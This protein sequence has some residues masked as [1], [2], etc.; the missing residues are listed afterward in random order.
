MKMTRI[1]EIK[2]KASAIEAMGKSP[3][4][5]QGIKS[6]IMYY[7]ALECFDAEDDTSAI[8]E[9]LK[10]RLKFMIEDLEQ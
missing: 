8:K 10:E 6:L 2:A 3:Y 1:E 9:G 4:I 7:Y 5:N